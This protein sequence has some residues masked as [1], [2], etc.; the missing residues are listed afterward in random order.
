LKEWRASQSTQGKDSAGPSYSKKSKKAEAAALSKA[1][2]A[3]LEAKLKTIGEEK[4]KD[5]DNQVDED[6]LC[7]FIHSVM[8][9]NKAVSWDKS[10]KT[11]NKKNSS[12]LNAI[13]NRA[14]SSQA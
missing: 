4:S 8:S 13:L 14:K 9:D 3:K 11:D 7:A 1:I 5:A 2:D 12:S 10:P 6:S